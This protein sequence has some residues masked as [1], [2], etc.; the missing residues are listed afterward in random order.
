M[1]KACVHTRQSPC[2][3]MHQCLSFTALLLLVCYQQQHI[4]V[5]PP[6]CAAAVIPDEGI[7]GAC[8]KA[9]QLLILVT[10]LPKSDQ[11]S[12]EEQLVTWADRSLAAADERW[13]N[14]WLVCACRSL[15]S[16]Y[17]CFLSTVPLLFGGFGLR[18]QVCADRSSHGGHTSWT[19]LDT[20]R[21]RP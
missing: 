7:L 21:F 19:M 18:V 9:R 17:V 11:F 20:D 13:R 15:L 8:S 6:C 1:H 4:L 5:C 12:S 16:V 3:P 10:M 14:C 2:P